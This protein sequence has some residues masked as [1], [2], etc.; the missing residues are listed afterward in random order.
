MTVAGKDVEV[1]T[2]LSK[3][4]YQ[5]KLPT[6]TA[7]NDSVASPLPPSSIKIH[8]SHESKSGTKILTNTRRASDEEVCSSKFKIP[9]SFRVPL[10]E[11]DVI[12]KAERSLP[13]PRHDPVISGALVMKRPLCV[14]NNRQVVDVVVD[15]ILS[16]HLRPHQRDGVKFLY[17]CVMGLRQDDQFGAVLADEMGLGKT[18][19]TITVLWTLLKQ[20][21]VHDSPP[22]VKKALVVCPVTLIKNWRKEFRKWLGLDRLGV[23]TFDDS[24]R[25]LTDF[26]RGKAYSVLIIGYEK[27]RA[28]SEELKLS[29]CIDIIIADEGHRLK[30]A[31]NKSAQAI[32]DLNVSRKILLTGTPI[33]NDLGELFVMA[34]FVNPG[35]LGSFKAFTKNFEVPIIRS[36][37][38]E[39]LE[40]DREKGS[41]RANELTDSTRSF[42]L[43]RTADLLA[44]YLPPSTEY[45]L[46]CRP[47]AI[48]ASI[49]RQILQSPMFQSALGSAEMSLQMITILKKLCN[50]PSL[51]NSKGP[52]G[53]KTDGRASI[54]DYV[55][56]NL[57]RNNQGSSKLRVLDR[58]L[59]TVKTETSE[60][61]VLVSHYTST[62]QILESLL[63]ALGYSYVRLDGSTPSQKRQSM[64]DEFNSPGSPYF[65]FL[66]S[67]KAGGIGINLTGASRLVLFDVDWNPA[68]DLQAMARIHRDGQKRPCII[69]RFLLAGSIDEKIWQR[70]VTKLGLASNVMD[71]KSLRNSFSQTDLRDLF[72]LH[73]GNSCQTHELLGCECLAGELQDASDPDHKA[74]KTDISLG[75]QF[76]PANKLVLDV[77]GFRSVD[78]DCSS[79]ADGGKSTKIEYLNTFAHI[80]TCMFAAQSLEDREEMIRDR[81]LRKVLE[82]EDNLVS[83]VFSRTKDHLAKLGT[84]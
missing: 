76:V 48:Q 78:G 24:K 29:Q 45:V 28:V 65:A 43:R 2:I 56:T 75:C 36:R 21:M 30:S 39:A 47:T 7:L 81:V 18:L 33:M 19:Q 66:L 71:Q 69:Y 54:L 55:P 79:K 16:K 83:F 15:P 51:L 61:I 49:Y 6:H 5:S 58:L 60:R 40:E 4:E 10:L 44:E 13:T 42:V 70:Q 68:T 3:D 17:E 27:L 14:Q 64:V 73:E 72:S 82:D 20:N 35:V 22:V 12:P 32:K 57:I 23:L 59:Y 52:H 80:D 41:E 67:A 31:K 8:K 74:R 46:M 63:T 11:N 77:E 38:P 25:R 84:S 9:G 62:L 26:T 50:S 53:P 1:D 37:Q 34:D